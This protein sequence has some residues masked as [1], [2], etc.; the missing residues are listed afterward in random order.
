[1]FGPLL[2]LLAC[3]GPP[4]SDAAD[5]Y[6][7]PQPSADAERD[8]VEPIYAL[9]SLRLGVGPAFHPKLTP[10]KGLAIDTRFGAVFVIPPIFAVWPE[11]GGSFQQREGFE[12]ALGTVDLNFGL[13]AFLYY[14]VGFMGGVEGQARLL[15]VR[16]GL[17]L[18]FFQVFGIAVMHHATDTPRRGLQHEVQLMFSLDAL[19]LV[20]LAGSKSTIFKVGSRRLRPG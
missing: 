15:G 12:R 6:R 17:D 14:G 1:M 2:A 10:N 11:I 5:N 4:E 8:D 18:R 3:L 16:H 13:P 19:A 20:P 7:P 9:L